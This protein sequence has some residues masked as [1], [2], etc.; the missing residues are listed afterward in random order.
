MLPCRYERYRQGEHSQK[1][2]GRDKAPDTTHVLQASELCSRWGGPHFTCS[3][4]LKVRAAQL[5]LL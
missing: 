4:Q 2:R 5:E 1:K 3:L